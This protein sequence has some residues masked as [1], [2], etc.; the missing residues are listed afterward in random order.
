MAGKDSPNL[1][2]SLL[3]RLIDNDP[4]TSRE[5]IQKRLLSVDQAKSAVIRDL[6]S[7]LN[8]KSQ[9]LPVPPAMKQLNNSVFV[10][11]LPDYTGYNPKSPSAKSVLRRDIE[12][13][14]AKFEPRLQ[15]VTVRIEN[16]TQDERNIRFKINALLVVDPL[17]EPVAFDTY[18][19]VNKGEYR[20]PR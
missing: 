3:D 2:A 15:N 16:A 12:K 7:L 9:I 11:G 10:Y 20:I 19:D 18:F 13:A 5:P 4:Q 1:Q 8:T 14:I 17:T 6:E